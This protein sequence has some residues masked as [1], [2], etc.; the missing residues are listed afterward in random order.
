MLIVGMDI[1]LVMCWV[2]VVGIFFSMIRLV[3][4]VLIVWVLVS[5]WLVVFCLCFWMWKLLNLC[6]DCGVSFRCVYIGI[7]CVISVLIVFSI[8][9]VVF[10]I[11]IIVVFVLLIRCVLVFSVWVVLWLFMNGRLV[12][13]SVECRLWVIVVVW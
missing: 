1:V 6:I 2:S 7:V 9:G 8:W 5:M 3:L 13:S 11:L 4:V 10:L 12:I